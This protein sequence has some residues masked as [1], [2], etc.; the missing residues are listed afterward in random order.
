[1]K[2]YVDVG[3]TFMKW[4]LREGE[5]VRQG[6]HAHERD[7][8]A[9]ARALAATT[10]VP[11]AEVHI[12]S[13]AGPE[14][15][16]L[17]K[18]RLAESFGLAPAFHYSES[19]ACGVLNA[20]SQPRRLGVDR[21]LA[22]IEAWHR[23]GPAVVIDC[24][25]AVTVDAVADARHLGGYIAPGLAMLRGGLLQNTADVHVSAVPEPSLAPGSSTTEGV[26]HGILVMSVAFITRAVVEL[27]QSLPDTC[28]VLLTGGD[29]PALL[30]WLD[31]APVHVPDL[32]LD[33]LERRVAAGSHAGDE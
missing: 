30:S 33:G 14:G 15:D 19:R 12:A 11:P 23:Y 28:C 22:V 10:D 31:E 18:E 29:A 27:R 21:W 5:Q 20:Y 13:V 26:E 7:W 25:S 32:V 3:N 4:R 24:G 1:M 8:L 6:S 17:L 9:V 16:R 2:L